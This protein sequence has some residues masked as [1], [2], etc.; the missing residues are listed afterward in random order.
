M[1]KIPLN[2]RPDYDNDNVD[3]DEEED[4]SDDDRPFVRSLV[5]TYVRTTNH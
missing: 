4:E 3:A 2:T 1:N 5:H